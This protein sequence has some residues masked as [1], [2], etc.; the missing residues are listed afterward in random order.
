[1]NYIEMEDVRKTIIDHAWR[2]TILAIYKEPKDF[3]G[4]KYVGRLYN[5]KKPTSL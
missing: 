5:G 2:G 1:M 3:E 4:K